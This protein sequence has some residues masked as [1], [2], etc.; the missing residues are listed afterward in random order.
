LNFRQTLYES[1]GKSIGSYD[2]KKEFTK[3]R[4]SKG[5]EWLKE[6]AHKVASNAIFDLDEAYKAF[7]R[8]VKRGE[9]PG[10][11]KFK[12][13]EKTKPAFGMDADTVRFHKDGVQIQK[14]GHVKYKSIVGDLFE[15][16]FKIYNTRISFSN[17]KWIL[18]FCT[19]ISKEISK[20]NNFSVGID[21]GIKTLAVV[22]CQ[23][24]FYKAK[25]INRSHKMVRLE[26][27]LKHQQRAL[28]RKRKR[29]KNRK[30]A[31]KKVQKIY[32][33]IS[34]I[35]HDYTHKVT[36]KIAEM[37]PERIV[38]ENLNVSG[39]LKNRHLAR[40][41]SNQNFHKFRSQL[42]YKTKERGI[43]LK[44]ADR[45]FPSSKRCSSC[46]GIKQNLK[47]SDRVYKCDCGLEID[48][49]E[50]AALNLENVV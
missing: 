31:L 12:S 49:D 11:P 41:I 3:V 10:F 15:V 39:M 40:A 38:I 34:K 5:M 19:E 27:Q 7:Y 4:N 18:S 50:N 28:S 25:N 32:S 16:D 9:K 17:N 21:L 33:R 22:S 46:G 43:E 47:L 13:K 42:D 30:K 8:R 45:F 35:R 44:V 1:E 14:V 24:N 37:L 26:K 20:L 48:R 29:S 2:L 23:G 6:V 36:T